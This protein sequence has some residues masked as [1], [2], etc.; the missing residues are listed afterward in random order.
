MREPRVACAA[1]A[2]EEAEGV[3]ATVFAGALTESQTALAAHGSLSVPVASPGEWV[4]GSTRNASGTPKQPSLAALGL[5]ASARARRR[6]ATA[7]QSS[8]GERRASVAPLGCAI[9][10]PPLF[11]RGI[12][13]RHRK[14]A[15]VEAISEAV[16]RKK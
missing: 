13:T 4:R 2:R 11:I 8:L 1:C 12:G 15:T 16:M 9:R 7:R 5:A 3:V 14:C 10:S 6:S